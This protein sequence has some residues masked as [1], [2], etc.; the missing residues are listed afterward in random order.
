LKTLCIKIHTI[1]FP[2]TLIRYR[3]YQNHPIDFFRLGKSDTNYFYPLLFEP[4]TSYQYGPGVDWAGIMTCRVNNT[5]LEDYIQTNI[6]APLN[7]TSTTFHLELKPHVEERL[8]GTTMRSGGMNEWTLAS[9]PDGKVEDTDYIWFPKRTE[10]ENGGAGLISSAADYQKLLSTLMLNDGKVLS[11]ELVKEM[12]RPQLS[13]S[14]REALKEFR[15]VPQQAQYTAQGQAPDAPFDYGL[16][17][18]INLEESP[19]GRRKGTIS[20]SGMPNCFWWV[21]AEAGVSGT[22]FMALFPVGDV[23]ANEF[24]NK[25]QRAV[26]DLLEK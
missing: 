4:G 7:M 1:Q 3:Q 15:R 6:C 8:V 26:Y 2:P 10:D 19:E 14:A 16:G 11:Q 18:I 5:N 20:W 9:D 24:F 13:P 21:D 22:L 25:F 23:K 17:S 12:A